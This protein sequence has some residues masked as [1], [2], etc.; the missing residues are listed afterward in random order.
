M[1]RRIVSSSRHRGGGPKQVTPE[2]KLWHPQAHM[3]SVK[4]REIRF[5][6]GRGSYLWCSEGRRYFD[7]PASLWCC[8]VGHGRGEIARAVAKQI[9]QLET[10][11]VFG[12]FATEPAQTL[13]ERL[14]LLCPIDN[15]KVF[16]GSGGSD[17]IDTAAKL[18]W[19]YWAVMDRPEKSLMISRRGA[20]HGLHV[21]GTSITGIEENRSGYAGLV[22]DCA[23]VDGNDA[24][25]LKSLIAS[26]GHERIAAMFCE[27]VIGAGGVI[28][29][30]PGYLESVRKLCGDNDI[31]LIIDEVIT[32]FGR[33]GYMFA[34]QR[35][36]LSPDILVVAKGL[37]SGY[38]PLGAAIISER[39]WRPFWEDGSQEIFHHGL[40]YSGHAAACAAALEN[41]TIIERE[42]LVARVRSLEPVLERALADLQSLPAVRS[43]RFGG[44]LLAGI[45]LVDASVAGKISEEALDHGLILRQI[46]S[47]TTLQISPPFIATRQELEELGEKLKDI[48]RRYTPS[49]A[50]E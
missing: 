33:T 25:A 2:T 12:P 1:T 37:T 45:E 41:L 27:P 34:S 28:P 46:K 38:L 47:G 23:L 49:E 31:L 48:I 29:P 44:G 42:D 6:R 15:P 40:T 19:R 13:A 5:T 18:A 43:V 3:P 4:R 8:N 50:P 11:S 26:V 22:R 39:L 20:Y 14:A 30:A 36:G 10:Y 16:F 7:V 24:S 17:A 21:F 32:G 35:Y 9:R